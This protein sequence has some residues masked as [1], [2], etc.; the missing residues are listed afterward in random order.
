TE[1]ATRDPTNA[2]AHA[3]L[4][5]MAK[6]PLAALA[7][8]QRAS[9]ADPGLID[10][11]LGEARALLRLGRHDEAAGAIARASALDAQHPRLGRLEFEL[12]RR[13]KPRPWGRD[14][15]GRP[16]ATIEVVGIDAW[17]EPVLER[18]VVPLVTSSDLPEDAA[19]DLGCDL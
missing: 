1:L 4:G 13:T 9:A 18:E 8:F 16:H 12:R 10:G 14:A 5:A 19:R 15:A 7:H 17:G 6:D 3:A 11:P 2:G